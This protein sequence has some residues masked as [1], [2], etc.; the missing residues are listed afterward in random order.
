MKE[1]K[2]YY[3]RIRENFGEGKED[4]KK[5]FI[6]ANRN[7]EVENEISLEPFSIR[8]SNRL[9]QLLLLFSTF[10]MK[11]KIFISR[12]FIT[13]EILLV[14]PAKFRFFSSISQSLPIFQF[15][16]FVTRRMNFCGTS[17]Q[18]LRH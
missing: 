9:F 2:Y 10:I 16:L 5:T 18:K 12:N 11:R 17:L 1:K 3:Q 14:F 13:N 6:N 15:T 7:F 4:G 8:N